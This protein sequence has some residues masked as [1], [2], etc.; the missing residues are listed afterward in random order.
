MQKIILFIKEFR[1]YNKK[2]LLIAFNSLPKKTFRF[3]VITFLVSI[4]SVILLIS[5][6]NSMFLVEVPENGG[7]IKEGIIGVPTLI[8]PVIANSDADKD[9]VALVYSGLMRKTSD[10]NFMPD[11]A[12]SYDLSSDGKTYTFKIKD[13]IKFHNG[14]KLTVDDIIFTINKIKDPSIKS[15]KKSSWDGINVEK[16]DDYT[17]VF[18]LNEPYISFLDNTTI[19]ILPQDLWKN[20]K[21]NEFNVSPMNIKAIGTGPYKI[22]SVSKDNDGIPKIYKLKRFDSFILGKPLIKKIYI[23][24][25]SNEKD[26][27][28]ALMNKTIDQAGGISPE[29]MDNVK[30]IKPIVYTA[31][32]PRIFG[33]FLNPKNNKIFE[34]KSVI[35]AFD[36]A[37][38]KKEII[39]RV[40][41]GYGSIINNPIPEKILNNTSNNEQFNNLNI[42]QAN[43]L[44]DK[45]GW[46]IGD[47]GI[48]KKGGA[49][50]KT[51]TKKVN[52]KN[53]TQII[54]ENT[55]EEKLSFTLITGDNPELKEAT[56]IIMEQLSQVGAE[57][58]TTKIYES[59]QL[60]Q[61]IRNREYEALFFGQIVNH[62]SDLYS[63]WHSSQISDPGL[64]IAMYTDKEIDNILESVQNITN[65]K[66]RLSKYEQLV[67]EF[68][69]NTGAIFVYSPEYIY[70]TKHNINNIYLG[71]IT[72]PSDRFTY[73]YKW[74]TNTDKIW[75][76]FK[77]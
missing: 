9:M 26:M 54:K 45:N 66:D 27:V 50:S 22:E 19:G 23:I 46:I 60:N 16:I 35:K 20:V 75:T 24:S 68:N 57:V 61:I 64:N 3:F 41:K 52:G 8:N 42:E 18:N 1:I 12:E 10:G 5:K 25:F 32:L 70:V 76:F 63:F 71:N 11:I 31:T 33:I 43:L 15:S 69:E 7:T 36:L 72:I 74:S 44:L 47:D 2:E 38:N 14:N 6:I 77:K 17:I 21:N 59:G 56:Q 73:V 37:L 13:N 40:L 28:K 49:T 58:D 34:D 39:D 4:I 55:P 30:K 62:E 53:V 67:K 51:V 29:N 48:R 65:T